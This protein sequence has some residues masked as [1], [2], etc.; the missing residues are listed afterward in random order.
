MLKLPVLPL[1]L[2]VGLAAC[3]RNGEPP[4]EME[5]DTTGM[6]ESPEQ[7]QELLSPVRAASMVLVPYG[8]MAMQRALREEI[9]RLGQTVAADHR[10][11]VAI[12]DSAA[13]WHRATLAETPE[14]RELAS[15][16]RLAHAG[17]EN[18]QGAEFDLTFIRAQVESHR[19]LLDRID[20]EIIPVVTTPGMETLLH[21]TRAMVYAHLMRAR[22]L[23]GDLLGEPLEPPPPG[24]TPETV[25][26]TPPVD[27]I[28]PP[29]APPAQPPPGGGGAAG[30]G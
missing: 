8:D 21:D 17:L 24:T 20:H 23:L 22:Q 1:V 27:T 3:Q 13:T 4:E 6:L 10:A 18:L 30:G 19:Q 15:G 2:L 5:G 16:V 7:V 25:P 11:L 12:L 26:R 28:P 29:T 9:R 14:G